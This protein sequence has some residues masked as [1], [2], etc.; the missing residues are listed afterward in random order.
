[1]TTTTNTIT[2]LYHR[3]GD[4]VSMTMDYASKGFDSQW[5]Q[6][7]LIFWFNRIPFSFNLIRVC[8][9]FTFSFDS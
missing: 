8:I 5:T 2:D 7:L 6:Q 4:C 9:R 3:F 1:M